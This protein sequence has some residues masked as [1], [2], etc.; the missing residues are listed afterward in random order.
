MKLNNHVFNCSVLLILAVVF[1]PI[2]MSCSNPEKDFEK[3]KIEN[4]IEIFEDYINKYPESYHIDEAKNMILDIALNNALGENTNKAFND[5]ISKYNPNNDYIL[6]I[7]ERIKKKEEY[8][9]IAIETFKLAQQETDDENKKQ[10][11][12]KSEE[13]FYKANFKEAMLDISSFPLLNFHLGNDSKLTKV[14]DRSFT[15]TQYIYGSSTN[16]YEYLVKDEQLNTYTIYNLILA[17]YGRTDFLIKM[18]LKR[19]GKELEICKTKFSIS[20]NKY[21]GFSGLIKN[22][23]FDLKNGDKIV[24]KIIASGDNYGLSC[25]NFKSYIR[26]LKPNYNILDAVLSERVWV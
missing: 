18:I 19:S 25:G 23:K 7:N 4:T 26:I 1:T 3:A 12:K 11:F 15:L 24:L 9:Q 16:K 22:K 5:F 20:S 13:L 6:K 21:T 10:L 8:L 2:I 17:S 14:I